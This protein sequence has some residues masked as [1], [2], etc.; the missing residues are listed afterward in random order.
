[1][2]VG[3]F[4]HSPCDAQNEHFSFISL[5]DDVTGLFPDISVQTSFPAASMLHSVEA[6]LRFASADTTAWLNVSSTTNS[7]PLTT[8]IMLIFM[9]F[10]TKRY[11]IFLMGDFF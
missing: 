11:N 2:Y 5:H 6:S 8:S 10:E 4:T 7:M 3:L 1:M 9:N